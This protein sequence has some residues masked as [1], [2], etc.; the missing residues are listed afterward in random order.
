MDRVKKAGVALAVVCL[1]VLTVLNLASDAQAKKPDVIRIAFVSDMSGP[2]A[3]MTRQYA[4]GFQ[5]G[6]AY[7]NQELG[8]VEGVPLE[9]LV[10]DTGGKM[11]ATVSHYMNLREMTPKPLFLGL[12]VSSDAEALRER[13]KED[14]IPIFCPA[15]TSAIYPLA[16]NF[17]YF[18]LYPDQAG[19]FMD[20]LGETWDQKRPAKLAF[21][22]WD[23]TYGRAVLT[24]EVRAYAKKKNI[25]IVAEELFGLR[26]VDVTTQLTRIRAK[27]ADWIYSN[28]TAHGPW[29]I[30]KGIKEMGYPVN[31]VTSCGSQ[32]HNTLVAAP[33]GLMDGSYVVNFFRSFADT[34]NPMMKKVREYFDKNNRTAKDWGMGYFGAF[35]FID[36]FHQ[37]ITRAVKKVGWD[38]LD[39]QAV[40]EAV[41]TFR[42]YQPLDAT[43]YTYTATKHS[44]EKIYMG[45]VKGPYVLPL[46]GG[47]QWRTC[48]DLRPDQ[49]K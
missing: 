1:V 4:I 27:G 11:D 18:P 16:Y 29:T 44:P 31:L 5:D 25:E 12:V 45:R 34:D 13:A 9:L 40:K 49:F 19:A 2:Y 17:A 33:P 14:Q 37:A 28:T 24:D 39:G 48:P 23:S 35:W 15:A 43:M 32:A 42:D 3:P 7:F 41:E 47:Y 30:A 21:L 20:W 22:T 10:R 46:G 38:K 26:D 8:G 6:L 36:V